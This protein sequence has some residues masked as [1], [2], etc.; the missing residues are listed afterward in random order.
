MYLSSFLPLFYLIFIRHEEVD[1]VQPVH[2]T[3]LFIAVD[4][5]MF[6]MTSS[7]IR[8]GLVGEVD[9]DLSIGIVLNCQIKFGLNSL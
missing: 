3:M 5:E 9:L 1:I 2:Q 6:R 8:D 7:E 4:V